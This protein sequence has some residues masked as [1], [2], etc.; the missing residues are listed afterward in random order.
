VRAGDYLITEPG[1]QKA[2]LSGMTQIAS[3]NK[4]ALVV[5]RVLVESDSDLS[6]AYDHSKQIQLI[7]LNHK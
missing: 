3:P 6:S 4:S 5:G 1:W 7:L 2:V